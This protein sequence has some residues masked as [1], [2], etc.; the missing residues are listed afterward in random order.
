[1]NNKLLLITAI[2]LLYRESQT[3][4]NQSRPVELITKV[5]NHIRTGEI[6]AT[7]D[8]ES[9]MINDLKGILVNMLNAPVDETYDVGLLLQ[10]VQIICEPDPVLF[11]AFRDNIIIDC[12]KEEAKKVS[13]ACQ[14]EI[15]K[16]FKGVDA[17]EILNKYAYKAKFRPDEITNISS[18]IREMVSE[19]EP[20]QTNIA[21][22]DPAVVASVKLSDLDALTEVFDRAKKRRDGSGSLITG[23]QG[24]NEML[25]GVGLRR[26]ELLTVA[27]LQHGN[28]SG[29]TRMLFKQIAMYNTPVMEDPNKKPALVHYSFED[30]L[31]TNVDYWYRNIYENEH[32]IKV[33]RDMLVNTPSSEKSRYVYEKLSATGYEI[34][35]HR[36]N[37]SEWTFRDIQNDLIRIETEGYE[38]HCC[39]IDYLSMIPTTGCTIGPA[40]VDIRDLFRRMRNFCSAHKITLITPH[41][42][43]TEAKMMARDEVANFIQKLVGGGYYSGTKQLDQ[44]IDTELFIHRTKAANGKWYQEIQR[45]KRRDGEIVPDSKLYFCMQF[46]DIGTL[47]DDLNGPSLRLERPGQLTEAERAEG[48]DDFWLAA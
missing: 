22:K 31:E 11:E 48:A 10:K 47:P 32:K 15:R 36:I 45:G 33:T 3:G 19:L 28:K 17:K 34:F 5:I 21:E 42:L 1:M 9:A 30:E 35:L 2:T 14:L 8:R 16:F 44:E 20:F 46:Q 13:L 26:G 43:S 23:W 7:L 18:F 25:D 12:G 39:T 29:F 40:G 6:D 4:S 41:Q 38:I 24:L 37:P 27:A